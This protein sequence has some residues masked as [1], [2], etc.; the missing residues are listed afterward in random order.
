MQAGNRA[1]EREGQAPRITITIV[2]EDKWRD[3]V[4]F[5]TSGGR[6]A[7]PTLSSSEIRKFRETFRGPFYHGMPNDGD[8]ARLLMRGFGWRTAQKTEASR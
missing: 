5:L 2:S 3:A 8:A 1:E 6:A 4:A 7:G